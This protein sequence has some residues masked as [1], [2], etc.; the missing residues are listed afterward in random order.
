MP[1]Y[2]F[3]TATATPQDWFP[4]DWGIENSDVI[5]VHAVGAGGRGADGDVLG[6]GGGGG[7]GERV[8]AE[9]TVADADLAYSYYV[10]AVNESSTTYFRDPDGFTDIAAALNGETTS[11]LVG[12]QGGSGGTGN[13]FTRAGGNG[14]DASMIDPGGGGGGG[15]GLDA[16]AGSNGSPGGATGGAGGSG[17]TQLGGSSAGTGGNGGNDAVNGAV[18][19]YY[20]S[21]GGGG[22]KTS[23]A[24]AS[25]RPPIIIVCWGAMLNSYPSGGFPNGFVADA[26]GAS[27]ANWFLLI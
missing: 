27:S 18:G 22:G 24:G 10:P 14:G 2:I 9:H 26:G 17:G 3:L 4:S 21:G 15:A 7:G 23:G 13:L 16:S 12:G 8:G 5:R 11:G 1:A 20:G 6:G 25:G 19:A